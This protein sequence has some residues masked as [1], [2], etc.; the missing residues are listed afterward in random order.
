MKNS[1]LALLALVSLAFPAFAQ[2]PFPLDTSRICLYSG[3]LETDI[4]RFEPGHEDLALIAD[5]LKVAGATQNFEVV[6]ANVPNVVAAL[7][8]GKRYLLYSQNFVLKTT[9]KVLVY[10]LLAHEIGH[11]LSGHR[12]DPAFR[13]KEELEADLF[14]GYVLCKMKGVRDI[15]QALEVPE[16]EPIGYDVELALRQTAIKEGW[17]R[18]AAA[19][20]GK[21]KLAY[22]EEDVHKAP[23]PPHKPKKGIKK[24]SSK[25]HVKAME[26]DREQESSTLPIP[27]FPWPPP[28]CAQRQTLQEHLKNAGANLADIDTRLRSALDAKGYVQRSY[29]QTPG[30]FALVT[31][32]EQ[33]NVDGTSKQGSG[34]WTDYPVQADFNS[35]WD[36]LKSLVMPVSGN[37][38]IFV[39]IVS[40]TPYNLAARRVPKEE[41][42]GWLSIGLN[43]LPEQIGSMATGNKHYLDVLVYEFEAPQSTKKCNPKCPCLKAGGEHMQQSGLRQSLQTQKLTD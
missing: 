28:Q 37:F 21:D 27:Q 16:Q 43:R 4:Y 23:T 14:M 26:T 38:R 18:A 1:I 34:R 5:I 13:I 22:Y 17:K 2:E 40:D 33:F 6:S 30:G 3:A 42:V 20:M 24:S 10:G 32:L 41:A 36:Y 19:L 8:K 15:D 35:V 12:F 39:F 25:P 9:D 29:F 7:I 11:H 31:Q